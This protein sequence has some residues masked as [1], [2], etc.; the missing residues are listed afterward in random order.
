M[1]IK[2]R[3]CFD[4]NVNNGGGGEPGAL[5]ANVAPPAANP[6]AANPPVTPPAVNPPA[7]NPPAANPPVTPPATNPPVTDSIPKTKEDWDRLAQDNPGKWRDLTQTRMDQVVRQSREAAERLRQ[8]EETNR[9]LAAELQR[10]KEQPPQTTVDPNKPFSR[11]NMPQTQEQWDQLW[12]ESP[13]MA[14]DLSNYK[15]HEDQRRAEQQKVSQQEYVESRRK[16][17]SI[18][19]DRHPD[20]YLLEKDEQ[21]NVKQDSNGKAIFVRDP[22]TGAPILDVESEKG[23]V[24]AQVYTEDPQGFDGSKIGPQLAM[25]EMERR[26]QE[27]GMQKIQ[28][29][30]PNGSQA[31]VPDQRGTLPGGVQPPV[32]GRVSFSSEDEKFHA[33]KA[34][35]RGTYKNLEEYCQHRDNK[36]AGIYDENS[37]PKF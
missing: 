18:L 17:A 19:Q 12:L 23:K 28:G 20:M 34:V 21:G 31:A 29:T 5:P 4:T 15:W 1:K 9:N 6:P 22:Q 36:S 10:F 26:L 11:E 35:E 25:N 8:A 2:R 33:T 7:V 30:N 37:T 14:H 13:S 32:T 27:Q 16:S 3:I 24:F